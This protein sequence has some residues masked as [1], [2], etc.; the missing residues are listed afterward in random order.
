MYNYKTYPLAQFN[1]PFVT[2]MKKLGYRNLR[3]DFDT[4]PPV[5]DFVA[6]PSLP[7]IGLFTCEI[8]EDNRWIKLRAMEYVQR[9]VRLNDQF[10]NEKFE[11]ELMEAF[12]YCREHTLLEEQEELEAAEQ[13][14]RDEY[15]TS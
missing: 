3:V 10:K 8:K 2:K 11:S 5:G 15:T 7:I 4:P 1:R 13:A 6:D 9:G 12:E 14:L